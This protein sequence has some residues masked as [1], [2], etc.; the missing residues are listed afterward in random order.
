MLKKI[1]LRPRIEQ[2]NGALNGCSHLLSNWQVALW[3][4]SA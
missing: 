4:Y 1:M 3:W 2:T